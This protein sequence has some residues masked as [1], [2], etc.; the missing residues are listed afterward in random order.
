MVVVVDG[1]GPA[2]PSSGPREVDLS[3]VATTLG[4]T[5]TG[6]IGVPVGVVIDEP[7]CDRDRAR[8]RPAPAPRPTTHCPVTQGGAP[9][10]VRAQPATTYCVARG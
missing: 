2:R 1:R 8:R 5:T 3:H 6:S 7:A 9:L 4:W 10:P